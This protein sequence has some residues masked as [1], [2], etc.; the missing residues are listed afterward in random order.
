[1]EYLC[2]FCKNSKLI[3]VKEI[4]TRGGSMAMDIVNEIL[5]LAVIAKNGLALYKCPNCGAFFPFERR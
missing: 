4:R 1:M 2:P 3:L 5:P